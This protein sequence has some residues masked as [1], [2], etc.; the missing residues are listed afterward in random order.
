VGDHLVDAEALQQH[1][2]LLDVVAGQ[3]EHGG[4][5]A[6]L[7][8]ERLRHRVGRDEERL[9]PLHVGL[10]VARRTLGLDRDELEGSLS[11]GRSLALDRDPAVTEG[12]TD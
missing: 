8:L 5:A 7:E 1:L 10:V 9:E 2:A 6:Q 12:S 4:G 3:L 11:E